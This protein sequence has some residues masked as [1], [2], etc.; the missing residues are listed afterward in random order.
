MKI[1]NIGIG[2]YSHQITNLEHLN[3]SF[4]SNINYYQRCNAPDIGVRD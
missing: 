4:I 3:R 1:F 2:L